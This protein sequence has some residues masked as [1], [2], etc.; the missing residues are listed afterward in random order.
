MTKIR[1]TLALAAAVSAA[2]ALA[3]GAQAGPDSAKSKPSSDDASGVLVEPGFHR[4]G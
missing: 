2:L 1:T 4:G 3:A